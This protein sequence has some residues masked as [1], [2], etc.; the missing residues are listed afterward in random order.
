MALTKVRGLGLGTLDDNI[1]FSTAGKGVHLG[2]TSATA[3]NLLDDFEE[4]TFEVTIRDATSGG[5]TGSV[6]QSNKYVKIG[7]KVWMQFNLI[8]ITTTGLTGGNNLYFTGLPFTPTSGSYGCG[9]IM[10]DRFNIDNNRYQVNIFQNSGQSYASVIQN[11]DFGASSAT[12]ST[13]VV[14]LFDNAT[15]DLFGTY[16]IEV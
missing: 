2:V 5:N 6:S 13:A 9:S 10:L 12:A 11:A 4:G 16:M 3:A 14:S 15:A 7:N 8:N 1:T